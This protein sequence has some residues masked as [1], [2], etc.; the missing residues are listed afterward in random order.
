M[1]TMPPD[2]Q[3]SS[4]SRMCFEPPSLL[5]VDLPL[6][7]LVQLQ[8]SGQIRR[9]HH[10]NSLDH[11]RRWNRRE[12]GK[13][14]K[15]VP[16]E[17]PNSQRGKNKG[18]DL[19]LQEASQRSLSHRD[20]WV[21]SGEG[22]RV[23]IPGGAHHW[24]SH[25]GSTDRTSGEESTTTPLLSQLTE[26]SWHGSKS[27]KSLLQRH[28]REHPDWLFHC[29]V[30]WLHWAQ[31]QGNAEGYQVIFLCFMHM[32]IWLIWRSFSILFCSFCILVLYVFLLLLYVITYVAA[33]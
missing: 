3:H 10:S 7:G 24:R 25:L 23:Q 5:S 22:Q 29:L 20:R 9:W 19:P 4:P 6:C 2:P 13:P 17:Q 28:H 1:G 32:Y 15:M 27:P 31:T 16:G 33:L 11:E 8:P 26:E 21:C 18:D 12:V 14:G 30:W